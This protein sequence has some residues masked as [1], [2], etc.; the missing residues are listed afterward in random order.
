MGFLS[1]FFQPRPPES[2]IR[3]DR[4]DPCWCG[5]GR[6]YKKCHYEED[7]KYFTRRASGACRGSI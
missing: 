2:A 6:K 7:R 3:L 1:R 5:S 4:N